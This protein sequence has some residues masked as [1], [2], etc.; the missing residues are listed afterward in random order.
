M[1][2]NLNLLLNIRANVQGTANVQQLLAALQA[3]GNVQIRVP[4]PGP[5]IT[6]GSNQ[7]TQALGGLRSS[8]SAVTAAYAL[9]GAAALKFSSNSL[10][11]ATDANKTFQSLKTITQNIGID[12]TKVWKTIEDL[13]ADG[14][15]SQADLADATKSLI[16]GGFKNAEL[17]EQQLRD[18]AALAKLGAREGRDAGQILTSAAEGFLTGQSDL[19][20]NLG[21]QK[22]FDKIFAEYARSIHTTVDA[23]TE[24]ERA[25]AI[26]NE[27]RKTAQILIGSGGQKLNESE[28]SLKDYGE[29]TAKLGTA[30]ET[31]K[32]KSGAAMSSMGTPLV[33]GLTFIIEKGF[34][35]LLW[36]VDKVSEGMGFLMKKIG[37]FRDAV[38]SSEW[39]A[40]VRRALPWYDESSKAAPAPMP[41]SVPAAV[42]APAALVAPAPSAN[43]RAPEPVSGPAP[44]SPTAETLANMKGLKPVKGAIPVFVEN[45]NFAGMPTPGLPPA[46]VGG[47]A[48][49]PGK[50]ISMKGFNPALTPVPSVGKTAFG[51]DISYNPNQA[52]IA[53]NKANV[54][55]DVADAQNRR[56]KG[57]LERAKTV[58]EAEEAAKNAVFTQGLAT[59]RAALTRDQES[60]LLS[61]A[62]VARAETGIQLEALTSRLDELNAAKARNDAL[63]ANN[64]DDKGAPRDLGRAADLQAENTKILGDRQAVLGQIQQLS[65]D[66]ETRIAAASLEIASETSAKRIAE[67]QKQ[68]DT[69]AT[70][71]QADLEAQQANLDLSLAQQ[72]ISQRQY[73]DEVYGM[74]LAEI[75]EEERQ[76]E[77]RREQAEARVIAPT[78]DVGRAQQA[79]EIATINAAIEA[80]TQKRARAEADALRQVLELEEAIK[81]ARSS[82]AQQSLELLGK[83]YE[84]QLAQIAEDVRQFEKQFSGETDLINERR[85]LADRQRAKASFDEQKRLS[86]EQV[87]FMTLAIDKINF[88]VEQGRMTSI[89][90]EKAIREER[91]KTADAILAQVEALEALAAANPGNKSLALEAG[92]A[93]L[94]YEKLAQTV[95]A[96][97]EGVNKSVSEGFVKG[98]ENA[99]TAA[100]VLKSMLN[101]LLSYLTNHFAKGVEESLSGLLGGGKSGVGFNF[102]SMLSTGFDW[103][104]GILGFSTGGGVRG[105]GTGTSD[106]ILAKLSNGEYVIKASSVNA[107]GLDTLHYINSLGKVPAFATGGYNYDGLAVRAPAAGAST[108]NV[109]YD[110]VLYFDPS[111]AADAVVGTSQFERKVV[112]LIAKHR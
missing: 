22:N 76:N 88:A 108:T 7:A 37:E 23:L 20:D 68:I 110:P 69:G 90:A 52:A 33:R 21:V 107:V 77:L 15:I 99:K 97:A 28:Q 40:A 50:P 55:K 10:K 64:L 109:S 5:T 92:Q 61:V 46:T 49:D 80:S 4:N 74:R 13:S 79:A 86:D 12:F 42:P 81:S 32:T 82:L 83:P 8:L 47:V 56:D 95:D 96:F 85:A 24:L 18:S 17:L 25:E 89:E 58:A 78:D 1:A 11:A 98:F 62:D 53:S 54:D 87:A 65:I 19:F 51:G 106:S 75:D 16:Q 63:I 3:L 101:S 44:P 45:P 6:A 100:D 94:E 112:S 71:F 59:R 14:L 73:L 105:P 84:A 103:M 48:I 93:R 30:W 36:V 41:M 60:G 91:L 34:D 35:P 27:T 39:A 72:L 43:A 29:A 2:N 67:L 31:L 104:K 102:G 26:A 111:A 57:A 38:A 66:N 9:A 70:M